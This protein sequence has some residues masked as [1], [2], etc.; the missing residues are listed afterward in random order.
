MDN[1]NDKGEIVELNEQ[2]LQVYLD[3]KTKI[4]KR[5]TINDFRIEGT[6]GEGGFGVV[7]LAELK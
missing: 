3:K 5:Y 2:N 1:M 6:L 7:H 4:N